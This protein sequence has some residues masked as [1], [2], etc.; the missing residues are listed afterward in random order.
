MI[1][2]LTFTLAM[3]CIS[4]DT[5]QGV[6]KQPNGQDLYWK[7]WGLAVFNQLVL[8]LPIYVA[9]GSL[10]CAKE[11]P[12]T[13]STSC[14][15]VCWIMGIHSILYYAVHKAFHEHPA[16]YQR[17]HRFHHRYN[18]HTPPS[19]ANAV[20]PGEYL[21]AYAL[22]FL[23]ALLSQPIAASSLKYAG[24][25]IGALNIMVH[26]PRLE[27]LSKKFVPSFWVST[28]NHLD[29]HRKLTMHYASPTFNVDNILNSATAVLNNDSNGAESVE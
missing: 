6:L 26:T 16:M 25:I 22:P 28:N 10:L 4:L 27:A 14:F 5:V 24:V 20:T 11:P 17:F 2:I 21:I 7:G 13:W 29:H 8:G 15:Q 9:V 23:P 19:A 1:G 18:V 12:A 3:E